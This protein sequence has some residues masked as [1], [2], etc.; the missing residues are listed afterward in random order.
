MGSTSELKELEHE[1]RMGQI[2]KVVDKLRTGY[3]TKSIV[4]DLEKAE[5]S[6]KFSEESSRT[7]HKLSNVELHELG[8]TSRTVQC[9]SCLK[10]IRE[11]S[12][13]LVACVFDLMRNKYIESK[14]DLAPW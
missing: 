1:K 9:Q 4:E 8:H 13:A 12:S 14:L 11:G 10:Q 2:Q 6:I 7:I 5:K 3:H